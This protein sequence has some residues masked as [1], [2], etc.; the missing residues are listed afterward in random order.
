MFNTG[1]RLTITKSVVE[2]ANSGLELADSS[3]DSNA[4]PAKVSVWARAFTFWLL[5][6][7]LCYPCC[8]TANRFKAH[9]H[10][11]IFEG[12]GLESAFKSADSSAHL[13]ADSY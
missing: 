13:W 5:H 7:M 9:T 11:P 10:T 1:S 4:D 6:G 8:T 2:L 12:S 3:A